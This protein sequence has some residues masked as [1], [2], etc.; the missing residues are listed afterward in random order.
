MGRTALS[1]VVLGAFLASA[2]RADAGEAA[3]PS[4]AKEVESYLAETPGAAGGDNAM[5]AVWKNGLFFET[6]DKAFSAH[7]GGRVTF[8]TATF[9][10]NDY[11]GAQKQDSWY[12]RQVW[13]S[14]DGTL[15][16]NAFWKLD[17]DFATGAVVL[18]NLYVGLKNLGPLGSF[19]AGQFK[20]PFSLGAVTSF[21]FITFMEVAAATG[22]FAPYYQDSFMLSNNFLEQKMLLAAISVY[23]TTTNGTATG[24]SGYGVAARLAAFFLDD[25]DSH[26]LLHL[27]F[28]YTFV[29]NPAGTKQF[30]ARPDIGTGTRF[31][32]TGAVTADDE[33][34][35]DFEVLFT[36]SRL[37]VQAEYY[38]AQLNGGG[39]PEPT[40]SGFYAEVSWFLWGGRVN[41]SK[42]KKVLD[43]PFIDETFHAGTGGRGAVQVALRYDSLDLSDSGVNGGLQNCITFGVNWYWNPQMRFM[44][45]VIWA[46]VSQGAPFG[47]GNLTIFGTRFQL[48]F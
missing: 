12:F 10:S 46:D 14:A 27:G 25:P 13:F 41:Y 26:R 24:N 33:A 21:R 29:S 15:Y 16:T 36:W 23:K 37:L 4:L 7:V 39:G 22:A 30:R 5:K 19:Q 45:N 2:R 8:D 9:G 43:R 28:S 34:V 20:Q 3:N 18:K 11:G 6:A 38:W 1:I 17:L 47:D 35:Y 42:T 40:F 44:F 32:D 48:D 31:V